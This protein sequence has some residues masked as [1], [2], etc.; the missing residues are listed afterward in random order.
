MQRGWQHTNSM[1]SGSRAYTFIIQYSSPQNMNVDYYPFFPL[2][3][4]LFYCIG[5]EQQSFNNYPVK[6]FRESNYESLK[7]KRQHAVNEAHLL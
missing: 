3:P 6:E 4:S 7:N 5:S 2:I 1:S